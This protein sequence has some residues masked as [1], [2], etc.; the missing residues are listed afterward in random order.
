MQYDKVS[1]LAW[2]AGSMGI[3]VGSLAYSF[4]TWSQPGPAFLPLLCGAVMAILSLVIFAQSILTDRRGD[5]GRG[6]GSFFTARWAK[7]AAAL[8]ILFA[9]SFFLERF[10]FPMMTFIFM[11]F[12]LKVVEPTGWRKALLVSVLATIVCYF[13]FES[14]LKIPMPKG[15]WP[16]LFR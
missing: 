7:L 1:S 15:F 2:L 12:T 10:G 11:I 6:G 14:W 4:G 13:L 16:S 9:Y 5:K 8:M 3:I